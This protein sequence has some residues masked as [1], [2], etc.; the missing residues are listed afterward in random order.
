METKVEKRKKKLALETKHARG[1]T[2]NSIVNTKQEIE[3]ELHDQDPTGDLIARSGL[4]KGINKLLDALPVERLE[5]VVEGLRIVAAESGGIVRFCTFCTGVHVVGLVFRVLQLILAYKYGVEIEFEED[6]ACEILEDKQKWL[7][8]HFEPRR[9]FH[10][11]MEVAAAS[12]AGPGGIFFL[13]CF[14]ASRVCFGRRIQSENAFPRVFLSKDSIVKCI[15]V[16]VFVEGFTRRM[17]SR[18]CFCRRI[19]SSIGECVPARVFVEGFNFFDSRGKAFDVVSQQKQPI[20]QCGLPISGF[21]C[22]QVSGLNTKGK[23]SESFGAGAVASGKGVTGSTA[24]AL[25]DYIFSV[26]AVFL[27]AIAENTKHLHAKCKETGESNLDT[28]IKMANEKGVCVRAMLLNSTMFGVPQNRPR[29]YIVFY[30]VGKTALL[31]ASSRSP[32]FLDS[33]QATV[34]A[35]RVTVFEPLETFLLDEDHPQ[36]K[37]LRGEE[38]AKVEAKSRRRPA[39]KQKVEKRAKDDD[40]PGCDGWETEHMEYFQH[41]GLQW[42]PNIESDPTLARATAHLPRSQA[43]KVFYFARQREKLGSAF[44]KKKRQATMDIASATSICRSGGVTRLA[45]I[46]TCCLA[47]CRALSCGTPSCS[48]SGLAASS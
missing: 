35:M 40:E 20:P 48:A 17:H 18:A 4:G 24:R 14:L 19:E 25:L 6:F 29:W 7:R 26:L 28:I 46:R 2:T 32:A 21:Q 34:E 45:W 15:P 9:L 1:I 47:P 5:R 27:F 44:K 13:C 11:M 3:K 12:R 42:P 22:D 31:S 10:D 16:R 39:K 36:I 33:M 38:N 41:A 8:L 43:E 30:K 37:K 23:D